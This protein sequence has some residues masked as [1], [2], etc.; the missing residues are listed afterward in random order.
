MNVEKIRDILVFTCNSLV[1]DICDARWTVCNANEAVTE[2]KKKD[3][4]IRN[5][6]PLLGYELTLYSGAD[7]HH[8]LLLPVVKRGIPSVYVVLPNKKQNC[9][10]FRDDMQKM[11]EE[12]LGIHEFIEEFWKT[13][14]SS[15]GQLIGY[16]KGYVRQMHE[17]RKGKAV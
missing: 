8:V 5:L 7:E 1:Y 12:L 11:H 4:S 10:V 17:Q 15:Q 6:D 9:F 14:T 2:L 3:P 16:E 13:T